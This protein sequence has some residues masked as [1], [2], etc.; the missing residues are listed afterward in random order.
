[1]RGMIMSKR[2]T[3]NFTSG[4]LKCPCC[5][6]S[7]CSSALV[8]MLQKLRDW[9]DEPILV[10]SA[11]RC[12]IYNTQIG[13]YPDSAHIHG[14]AA[15]IHCKNTGIYTLAQYAD[16]LKFERIGLYPFNHFI[17]VDMYKKGTSKYWVRDRSGDYKYFKSPKTLKDVIYF[18]KLLKKT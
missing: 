18:A 11:Y 4:E 3:K 13:G 12:R 17:H 14:L 5:G 1:M 10:T 15:D 8:D 7:K 16:L 9:V 6:Q 2:L